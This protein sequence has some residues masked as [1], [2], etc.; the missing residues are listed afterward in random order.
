MQITILG[1]GTSTGIP[2]VGCNC[3]VCSSKDARDQRTRSS[4]LIRYND[5][6][7]LVDTST[8]LRQQALQSGIN[9]IDAV[10]YTHSHADHVN[11]IDD[12]RGFH[13]INK[14]VIPCYAS[15]MTLS[16]LMSGFKYIFQEYDDSG[17]APLLTAHVVNSPFELFGRT[18][19][20]IP[21]VHGKTTSLGYR[22]GACAYLTDC[23]SIPDS[24]LPLLEGVQVLVIDSLRWTAH[25]SHFNIDGA[26]A[27]T[28]PLGIPRV[29]LTHLTHEVAHS[30]EAALPPGFEF[31]YDGLEIEL[32]P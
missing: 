32:Q 26:M 8:D 28:R 21:L 25:P 4:L 31:A 12:L 24:S 3:R 5:R 10:L 22:I 18:V 30:D 20:P 17:Y 11:G 15:G 6:T 13:F 14:K 1:S 16:I 2:M 23:S 9:C 7:I 29:I 27:A 19:V